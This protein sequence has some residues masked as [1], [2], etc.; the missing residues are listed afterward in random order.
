V[1]INACKKATIHSRISINKAKGTETN[2]IIADL[3][4]NIKP[5]NEMTMICPAV[6]FANKRIIKA[7][8]LINIPAIS[9]GIN[10]GQIAFGA[11][12]KKI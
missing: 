12:G 2:P 3:N 9:I 7:I 11:C 10:I 6:I 4:T 8:G 5:I 1:K